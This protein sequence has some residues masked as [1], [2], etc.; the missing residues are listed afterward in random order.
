M[1]LKPSRS[2]P[3][4]LFLL[5]AA[6]SFHPPSLSASHDRVIQRSKTL[7][8][9]SSASVADLKAYTSSRG[10]L[11]IIKPP[12]IRHFSS[13]QGEAGLKPRFVAHT[14]YLDYARTTNEGGYLPIAGCCGTSPAPPPVTRIL[15]IMQL[16]LEH[17][18]Q[19]TECLCV[20]S[21]SL[22]PKPCYPSPPVARN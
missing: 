10:L 9:I 2:L 21:P 19:K 16:S 8:I 6:V 11:I 22:P 1:Q 20:F 12:P 14:N 15:L 3:S 17:V 5:C 13:F 7:M 18:P 4:Q